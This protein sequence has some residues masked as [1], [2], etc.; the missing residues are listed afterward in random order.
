M[1]V[2]D[3]IRTPVVWTK[4]EMLF[5]T[6]YTRF[7]AEHLLFID[8]GMKHQWTNDCDLSFLRNNSYLWQ[9]PEG[10]SRLCTGNE[11]HQMTK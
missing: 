7:H 9:K 11:P 4:K 1:R 2:I 8:Q 6:V 5:D 10:R 3:Y